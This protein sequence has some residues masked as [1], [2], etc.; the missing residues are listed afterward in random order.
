MARRDYA[1]ALVAFDRTVTLA[2]GFAQGWNKRATVLYLLGQYEQSLLDCDKVLE[3]EPRHFGALS[4]MGLI[5]M[6]LDEPELAL[7][8]FERALAVDPTMPGPRHNAE[9]L[10][11]SIKDRDI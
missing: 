8:A 4:G 1:A 9:A 11:Q 3:L 6:A 5:Y 10:R 2:P 7:E